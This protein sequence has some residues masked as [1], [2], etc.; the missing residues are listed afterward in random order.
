MEEE[1]SYEGWN[2]DTWNTNSVEEVSKDG[3]WENDSWGD[4]MEPDAKET[5]EDS[6]GGGWEDDIWNATQKT[7]WF[8]SSACIF[9]LNVLVIN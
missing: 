5:P 6:W 3:G 8:L 9:L 1:E 2:D 4:N 7:G